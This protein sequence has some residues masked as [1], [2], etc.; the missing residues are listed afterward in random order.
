MFTKLDL[1]SAYNLIQICDGGEWTTAFVKPTGHYEYCIMPYGLSTVFQDFMHEVLR[2]Y[3][4]QFVLYLSLLQGRLWWP[5][6][7]QEVR[8][9]VQGC[10]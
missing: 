4:D 3:L 9:S 5:G 10:S 8:R 6:I 2:E 1:R 7:G